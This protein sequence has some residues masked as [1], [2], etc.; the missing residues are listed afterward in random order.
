MELT[1]SEPISLPIIPEGRLLY[2]LDL[3]PEDFPGEE[4]DDIPVLGGVYQVSN[5]GRLKSLRFANHRILRQHLD[6]HR[7]VFGIVNYQGKIT[8]LTMS[9][10]VGEVFVRPVEDNE[11][12]FHKNYIS[13]DN[14]AD[15]LIPLTHQAGFEHRMNGTEYTVK[16]TPFASVQERFQAG[17]KRVYYR[18]DI[19]DCPELTYTELKPIMG[20]KETGNMVAR[21]KHIDDGTKRKDYP[22][23]YKDILV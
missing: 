7:A 18:I 5:M 11:R 14:R 3:N 9:K 13:W 22:W 15:N 8:N 17:I 23:Y 16:D 4:W 19:P 6:E 12:F 1:F 2:H 20:H 21:L 10:L